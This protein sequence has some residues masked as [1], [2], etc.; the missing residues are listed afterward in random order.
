M[1]STG[2]LS[3]SYRISSKEKLRVVVNGGRHKVIL[4][5]RTK[6]KEKFFIDVKGDTDYRVS[7]GAIKG[8]KLEEVL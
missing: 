2:V 1:V 7:V 8:F 3:R 5:D 6:K 4:S